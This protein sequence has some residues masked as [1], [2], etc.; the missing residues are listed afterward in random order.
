M[1]SRVQGLI[2]QPSFDRLALFIT[3]IISAFILGGLL[4]AVIS[5]ALGQT[6]VWVAPLSVMAID[7]GLAINRERTSRR[8]LEN[9]R[10]NLEQRPEWNQFYHPPA[11][12]ERALVMQEVRRTVTRLSERGIAPPRPYDTR[13]GIEQLI[14]WH[15]PRLKLRFWRLQAQLTRIRELGVA[16]NRIE[17]PVGE[18]TREELDKRAA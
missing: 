15:L 4:G 18:S 6:L 2:H 7:L 13:Q 9:W 16:A 5:P 14:P 3:R 1:L 17:I 12:K 11:A 10:L 8:T